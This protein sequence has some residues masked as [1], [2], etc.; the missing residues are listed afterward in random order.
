[1]PIPDSIRRERID[2]YLEGYNEEEWELLSDKLC[3]RKVVLHRK[4][5][6]YVAI[7]YV[8]HKAVRKDDIERTIRC[9]A[10]PQIP[11]AKSYAGSTLLANLMVGKYVDSLPF[12]RQIEMMKRLGMDIPPAT[13]SDWFKDVA[14]LLRPLYYRIRDPVMDTDYIQANETTVPIVDDEKHR[15]V[16]GYLWQICAVTRKLLFFHYDKGSRSKDVALG[17]FAHFRG[18][19]QADDYAVCDYYEGKDGG[20]C[21]NCWGHTRRGL[22]RSMSNDVARSKYA[23]EQIGLLYEVERKADDGNL[24]CDERLDLRMRLAVPILQTFEVWLKNEA[25]KALPRSSIGKVIN[26]AIAHYD[27]I[28]DNTQIAEICDKVEFAVG[29]KVI[30]RIKI[31]NNVIAAPNAVAVK[32]VPNNAIVGGVPAT[33]IKILD[34]SA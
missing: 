14:D 6:E 20:L 3:E 11:I 22:D 28:V 2:I 25:P 18:A 19:L 10:A 1:M 17:L 24:T 23:I 9:A 27:R 15:T 5:A 4:T 21:L 33:I 16:K 12:Y 8:I 31:G 13:V 26:Y 7:E 32:D 30:G 34:E 29:C